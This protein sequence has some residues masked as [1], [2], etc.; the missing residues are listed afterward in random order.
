MEVSLLSTSPKYVFTFFADLAEICRQKSIVFDAGAAL[1]HWW[2]LARV[3][4]VALPGDSMDPAAIG[5]KP[6]RLLVTERGKK[7]LERGEQSPHDPPKY[8][9]TV[10]RRVEKPDEIVMTYLDEAVGAWSAG[11]YR[12]SAVTLGCACERLVLLLAEQIAN[13]DVQ[14]WSE[15]IG[16][17][18][19]GRVVVSEVFEIARSCLTQLAGENQLPG[20]L[21]DAL[22]RKLSAIFDHARGLRNK[23]GHPTGDKVSADDAEAG[24]LLFPGF[25]SFVNELCK[26]L[27]AKD[28]KG[29]SE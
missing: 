17:K 11:L 12:A 4:V 6:C 28:T 18:L 1:E 27:G 2:N 16:K 26:H 7:L 23:Y 22:D 14:P 5:W 20:A 21:T 13:A 10:S 8:L 9:A 24:L 3:G 19:K 29:V 15:R 25:Y